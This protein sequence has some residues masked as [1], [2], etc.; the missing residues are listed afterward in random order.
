MCFY[1]VLI[2][3]EKSDLVAEMML[4]PQNAA[5]RRINELIKRARRVKVTYNWYCLISSSGFQHIFSCHYAGSCLHHTLPQ[6][7][8]ALHIGQIGETESAVG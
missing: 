1:R 5:V 8:D 7:T 3:K 2:E 4:L 6:E